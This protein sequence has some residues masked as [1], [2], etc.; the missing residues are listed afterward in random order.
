MTATS[1]HINPLELDDDAFLARARDMCA[2]KAAYTTRAEAVTFAKRHGY[3]LSAYRCPWCG[4]WH[5]TSYDRARAKAF[6]RR[7]SRLLRDPADDI[8]PSSA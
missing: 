5:L 8:N 7:L 2:S 1:E 3:A 6:K 4:H